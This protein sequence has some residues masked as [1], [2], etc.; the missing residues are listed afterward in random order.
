MK[1]VNY[2]PLKAMSRLQDQINQLFHNGGFLS[3]SFDDFD[4]A[5]TGE[6]S[7]SVN[8]KDEKNQFVIAADIPGVDPK[9]IEVNM[10]NGVLSIRG[11]RKTEKEEEEDGYRRIECSQGSFYRRFSLPETADAD[12][13]KAKGRNGVLEI[14]IG[15]KE[16]SKSKKIKVHT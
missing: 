16:A 10:E 12:S 1:L 2:E 7:P 6:W 8:V 4:M 14:T 9:D 13:V 3:G 5:T 11:E 15:K